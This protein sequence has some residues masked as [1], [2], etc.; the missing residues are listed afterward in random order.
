LR[1]RFH[2]HVADVADGVLRV[3]RHLIDG[4]ST[5]PP[6][7]LVSG[8]QTSL[9]ALADLACSFGASVTRVEAPPRNFDIHRFAGDPSRA[10][11]LLGWRATTP[12]EAGFAK[13]V[14]DCRA[15]TRE[16]AARG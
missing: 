7:H 3:V 8:R 6:I 12:L 4:D 14:N 2:P 9:G 15:M 11:A 5:L 16:S 1:L 10:E 13:L